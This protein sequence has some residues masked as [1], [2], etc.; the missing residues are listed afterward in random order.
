MVARNQKS[1][2]FR[3]EIHYTISYWDLEQ[4]IHK[5]CVHLFLKYKVL[6]EFGK[7]L[8]PGIISTNLKKVLERISHDIL[9]QETKVI[10]FSEK[11]A[12]SFG[13]YQSE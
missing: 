7:V 4:I 8:L 12:Q 2:F 3:I 1:F 13:S 10:R 11:T 5:I 6:N 9:L